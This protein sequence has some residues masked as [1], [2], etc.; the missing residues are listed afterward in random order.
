MRQIIPEQE[1]VINCKDRCFLVT[2]RPGRGKTSVG[3]WYAEKIIKNALLGDSQQVMFLTFSRNAVYQIATESKKLL[4]DQSVLKRIK[5]STYH[6]FMWWLIQTFGR[7]AALP[8]SLDLIW[9]T[10]ARAVLFDVGNNFG[11]HAKQLASR[12]NGITYECFA[13]LASE[14]LQTRAIR[15]SLSNLYPFVIV[16]E[17]QDTNDDQWEI[18]KKIS[19]NSILCCFADP[20]QM[21]HR[22]RGATDNRLS[23]LEQEKGAKRYT[24]QSKC[25]RTGEHDL[26]DFAE[27]ILENNT[28]ITDPT[29]RY[30]S[31]FLKNYFGPNAISYWLKLNLQ[32]FYADYRKKGLEGTPTIAFAA[33]SNNSVGLIRQN[34]MKKSGKNKTQYL[35][36]TLEPDHDETIEDLI[37]H[38]ANWI[39]NKSEKDLC[40]SIKIIGALLAPKDISKASNPI[41]SLFFPEKLL[42]GSLPLTHTAKNIVTTLKD[43][44]SDPNTCSD[45]LI[46]SA[47]LLRDLGAQVKKLKNILESTGLDERLGRMLDLAR[48]CTGVNA[49]KELCI[50]KSKISNDRQN[51]CI[52]QRVAPIRGRIV[53]TMHKLKG[54]EFDYVAVLAMPDEKFYKQGEESELDGRRL[55]Y[56]ALTRARYDARILYMESAPPPLLVPYL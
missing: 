37:I 23:V 8:K 25:L 2:S 16:D 22:F 20:D 5:I 33:Y 19:E 42:A 38:I 6:S 51:R 56:V 17:F 29:D 30:K 43:Y 50:L 18:I 7:F 45:I 48:N 27:A 31:K 36:K 11:K 34:L 53:T 35:C 49:Y 13:P 44:K 3:L 39:S 54:K 26:L 47:I 46:E 24:L 32:Q 12:V 10:K 41:K 21:I 1:T 4:R 40:L 52:L 14:L 15:E 9:D 28:P 55:L